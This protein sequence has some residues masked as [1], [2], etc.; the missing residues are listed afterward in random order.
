MTKSKQPQVFGY[1]YAAVFSNGTIKAGMSQR[2]PQGRI[3]SHAHSGKV[4][5]ISL[6]SSFV[7]TIYTSDVRVRE[8]KMHKELSAIAVN[9]AGR[10]WFKFSDVRHALNFASTHLHQAESESFSAKPTPEEVAASKAL[11]AA[12]WNASIGPFKFQDVTPTLDRQIEDAERFLDTFDPALI[13][14]FASQIMEWEDCCWGKNGYDESDTPVLNQVISDHYD[15]FYE[16][17][18]RSLT[19]TT[20]TDEARAAAIR[21]GA[22]NVNHTL[23]TISARKIISAAL[24]YPSFFHEVCSIKDVYVKSADDFD[25]SDEPMQ[26]EQAF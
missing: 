9:T 14:S 18:G 11:N 25:P 16:R 20:W 4:F 17:Y 10:E 19:T 15:D 8:K 6:E 12:Q 5:G 23:T 21:F 26:V 24:Q 3:T 2:D 13:L 1:L 7:A 22:H